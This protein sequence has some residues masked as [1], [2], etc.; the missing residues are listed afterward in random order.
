MKLRVPFIIVF[1]FLSARGA[2]GQAKVTVASL[3]KELISYDA[4]AQ[5][6]AF[7]Y[8]AKQA[9]SYDRRSVSPDSAGWYA[10]A[11][12]GQYIRKEQKGGHEEWVMMDADGPGAIVRFWLTTFKRNGTIRI[13]FDHQNIASIEIPA[14]DLMKIG[15]PLGRGLLLPHSSYQPLEKGGSTLYLPLPYA[16][17]CKVTLEDQD[18]EPK[19]PRYY[20]INYRSYQPSTVVQTFDPHQLD[21]LSALLKEADAKLRTPQPA[22]GK[23][24]QVSQ[25]LDPAKSLSLTLPKGA[26]AVRQLTVKVDAADSAAYVQALRSCILKMDFDGQQTVWCP[27][28]DFAGSGAG[29]KMVKSWY[30]TVDNNG[31]ITSRWVM[32]YRSSGR[33]TV[34]NLSGQPVKLKLS[35][36]VIARPWTPNSLYFYANWKQSRNVPITNDENKAADWNMALISGR[37]IYMGNTMA[38]YNHMHTWYGEGDQKIWV[39]QEKFPS[40]FGTGTEDYYNTSWAPVVLYQT[41]FANA[42]R[43]DH[44]DSFGHNTFTRTRNLDGV[45]F[46]SRFRMELEMLGWKT[47]EADFAVTTY[48]YGSKNARFVSADMKAEAARTLPPSQ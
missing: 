35:V 42:P 6:P 48:W 12:Q 43:A 27:I 3:L 37:G 21:G 7:P 23:Q 11:D 16:K 2:S 19:Q 46:K 17:H 9:S 40:E 34:E 28:G 13:Y 44:P 26:A 8:T 1:I 15:L 25:R 39:D 41:P 33:I 5:W 45:P 29:G 30:R 10:N 32:P 4:A 22:A 38:V 31:R 14:Y 18:I 47:G 24:I 20:Q 36:S